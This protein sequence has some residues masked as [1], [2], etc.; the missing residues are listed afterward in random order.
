M[1]C[2][3]REAEGVSGSVLGVLMFLG[4]LGGIV[5]CFV[6]FVRCAKGV[7]DVEEDDEGPF[8]YADV[9]SFTGRRLDSSKTI[10]SSE[11][12]NHPKTRNCYAA[13][14]ICYASW[15]RPSLLA[16]SAYVVLCFSKSYF[17]G[18][19]DAMLWC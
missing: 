19:G 16:S 8:I 3:C 1:R 14:V 9:D 6:V 10:L 15:S 4:V 13:H 17:T 7:G 2:R 5:G 12:R 18:L 11:S